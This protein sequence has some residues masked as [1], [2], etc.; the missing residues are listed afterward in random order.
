MFIYPVD[1]RRVTSKYGPRG[2]GFHNGIDFGALIPGREGNPIYAVADGKVV[3]SKINSGGIYK[4][5]GYYVVVEHDNGYC[6]LYA[7][8]Q[9]LEVRQGQMVKQGQVIGH[10]GNTGNSTGCHLHFEIRNSDYDRKFFQRKSNGQYV[11]SINPLPLLEEKKVIFSDV[12]KHWAK[13]NIEKVAKEGIMQGFPDGE[14]KPNLT[15]TRAELAT[16]AAN[17]LH[18]LQD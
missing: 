7:H 6:S 15:V 18:K 16:V 17:I 14:F 5:Y 4:G 1:S 9:K 12:E 11:T 10:M 2:T 3:I 13:L 8:L